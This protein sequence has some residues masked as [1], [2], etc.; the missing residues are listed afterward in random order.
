MRK[1]YL[2]IIALIAGWRAPVYGQDTD[3]NWYRKG[4]F[5]N[6]SGQ[7]DKAIEAF[8]KA[9][10]ADPEHANA[11]NNRGAVWYAKKEWDKAIAD[12]TRAI[13]IDPGSAAFYI[14]R[15]AVWFKQG[16]YKKTISDYNKAIDIDPGSADAFNNRGMTWYFLAQY[17]RAVAD[18]SKAIGINPDNH[19]YHNNRGAAYFRKNQYDRSIV[20]YSRAVTLDPASSNAYKNRGIA[21]FKKGFYD[22]AVADYTRA[23]ETASPTADMYISRGIAYYQ[24]G[25]YNKALIDFVDAVTTEPDNADACNQLAW[26]LA[27]CPDSDYRNG[28][29]AVELAQKAVN[30]YPSL[31]TL[32]TLAAAFAEAGNFEEAIAHQEHI[33]RHAK[34]STSDVPAVYLK[35]LDAYRAGT[36]W[37]AA[38]I[39][40]EEEPR[41]FPAEKTIAVAGGRFRAEPSTDSFVIEKKDRGRT[42][43]VLGRDGQWYLVELKENLFAWA[44]EGLFGMPETVPDQKTVALPQA[45]PINSMKKEPILKTVPDAVEVSAGVGRIRQHPSTDAGIIYKVVKGNRLE[46]VDEKGDWYHVRLGK[47]KTGWAHKSLFKPAGEATAALEHHLTQPATGIELKKEPEQKP[48][49]ET[50]AAPTRVTEAGTMVEVTA[51]VGR[52]RQQPDPGA[53]VLYRVVKGNRL[54]LLEQKSGWYR[55][56][57][58]KGKTGWGHHSLF[59]PPEKQ[60]Q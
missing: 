25:L 22:R 54:V 49:Q 60:T 40:P 14:N 58:G 44:Y 57:L 3:G 46:L 21:W 6:R 33:I 2:I 1:I 31:N 8:T 47:N 53:A 4:M 43:T 35:K 18:Y 38:R 9:I 59:G 11:Y 5:F 42:V 15:G 55:V 39:Y 30:L 51:G 36:P 19:E 56:S 10:E 26:M 24:K 28:A 37:R 48:E 41:L 32:D 13:E 27:V 23:M 12:Y 29:K 20:D 16:H 17:D 7:H 52:I 50:T 45:D 34:E